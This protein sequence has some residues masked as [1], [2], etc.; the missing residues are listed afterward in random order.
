M[1]YVI[2]ASSWIDIEQVQGDDIVAQGLYILSDIL[3]VLVIKKRLWNPWLGAIGDGLVVKS[4]G[5]S[6]RAL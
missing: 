1:Y 2:D 6:F 4:I 5:G 3:P